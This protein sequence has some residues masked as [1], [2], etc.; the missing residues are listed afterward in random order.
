MKQIRWSFISGIA[1]LTLFA[2]WVGTYIHAIPEQQMEQGRWVTHTHKVLNHLELLSTQLR[3]F[4]S[5]YSR[6]LERAQET[7]ATIE[8]LTKD[9]PVQ[10]THI[11]PLRQ[12]IDTLLAS[13]PKA[14]LPPVAYDE[15]ASEAI[16]K[17]IDAMH[18]EETR[19]L[20]ER[21]ER[22]REAMK[23][24][25][26]LFLIGVAGMYLFILI[27]YVAARK[28]AHT[29]EQI[30]EME[31]DAA[32]MHRAIASRMTQVVE[33]QHEIISHRL[34]LHGAMQAIARRAQSITN[35]EGA[36]IEMLEADEM[37]YHAG[38]GMVTPFI[39][40]RIKAK[41]S[42]SGLCVE[43]GATQICE[44]SETDP[45][46]DK[47][48][49]RKVGV[50]SMMVVPLIHKD[51]TMGVLKVASG[52]VSGFTKEDVGTLQLMAGVLT[53]TLRDAIASEAL[54]DSQEQ[55][56]LSNEL[57]RKQ[58]AQLE[59]DKEELKNRADT[60]SMTGL[61][62]HRFFQ[63]YLEQEYHRAR[64][65]K[66]ELSV[67]MVDIDHFK[68][69]ND[70]FGHQAG[71]AVISQVAALLA[72]GVRPSD[73]VA[74]YGGEEFGIILTQTPL[75]GAM[76]TAE[77]LRNAITGAAWTHRPITVSIGV[78]SFVKDTPD[79]Q[80]LVKRA[81]VAL[82]QSKAAGRDRITAFDA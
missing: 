58:K 4:S 59:S 65:Y 14:G 71:D 77:H 51:Q 75:E 79:A 1:L 41:G 73:C 56:S 42:L 52:K 40:I 69:F 16:G 46:V 31:S 23:H 11:P 67:I 36:A 20:A 70:T 22:W 25:S 48:I 37:V 43:T 13:L 27:A 28:E 44:D 63:E 15:A 38:S 29:H 35:A 5:D 55:L 12:K 49:C 6:S 61:R 10:Q 7:L 64:R 32:A 9:N 53:S 26:S 45:R 39:G 24:T 74:R 66:N 8:T 82:Y 68:S 72:G 2:V 34:D 78:S 21:E 50:R 19:L 62:N 76:K 33:A 17:Q 54:K 57:L 3:G 80:S 81:D 18:A 47:V 30:L 60:D